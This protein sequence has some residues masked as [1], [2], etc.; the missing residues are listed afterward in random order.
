MIFDDHDVHDDWNTSEDLGRDRC[1]TSPG[2]RSASSGPSRRT[3][4]TSTSATSPRG[5]RRGRPV[6]AGCMKL[7]RRHPRPARVRLQGRQGGGGDPLELPPRLRQ[8]APDRHGLPRRPGA[9]RRASAR[10]STRRSGPGSRRRPPATSTTSSSAPRSRSSSRPASTTSRRGARRSATA[11]GAARRRGSA[12][13]SVSSSTSNTGPPSTHSFTD[14]AGPPTLRR[15]RRTLERRAPRLR[16]R[17]LRR[18]PPRLPRRGRASATAYRAPSTRR[19]APPCATPSAPPNASSCAPAGRGPVERVGR[20]ARP[21]R[22]RHRS[23]PSRWRL[24]HEE[25]W[26]DNHISTLET[27]RPGSRPQ[28]REDHPRRRG[29]ATTAKDPATPACLKHA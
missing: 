2:G 24:T 25:P 5:A 23:A 29:R 13:S 7:G 19:S 9:R 16:R 17:P 12:S 14:L 8:G 1:A 15:R 3:G 27:P 10:C 28:G 20:D 6:P 4:S 18:R 26:F 11:P 22:R 21:P